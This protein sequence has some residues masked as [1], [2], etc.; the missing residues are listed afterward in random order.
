MGCI[1][2]VTHRS[3]AASPREI[4]YGAV[5]IDRIPIENR[6]LDTDFQT[7]KSLEEAAEFPFPSTEVASSVALELG[8]TKNLDYEVLAEIP[9]LESRQAVI[10]HRGS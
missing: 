9:I 10:H 7:P 5:P 6:E 8:E 1:I 2:K 3:P 4:Y